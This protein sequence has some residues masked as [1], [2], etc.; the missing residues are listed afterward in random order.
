MLVGEEGTERESRGWEGVRRRKRDAFVGCAGGRP[1]RT[2]R[3]SNGRPARSRSDLN[4]V[5]ARV[6]ETNV[7]DSLQTRVRMRASRVGL[8]AQLGDDV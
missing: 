7:R 2:A 1:A 3:A 8:K 4:E 5:E 6:E